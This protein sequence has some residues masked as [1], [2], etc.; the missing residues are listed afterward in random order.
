[1]EIGMGLKKDGLPSG[2]L[3]VQQVPSLSP[4]LSVSLPDNIFIHS[5]PHFKNIL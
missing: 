4:S 1:M 5:P 2:F 3:S